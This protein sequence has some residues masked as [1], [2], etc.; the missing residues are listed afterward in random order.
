MRATRELF[1]RLKSSRS[2][3]L[4][5]AALAVLVIAA[6]GELTGPKSPSTPTGVVATLASVTSATITWTPSPLNDGVIS[7]SIYRNGTKVG[8]SVTTSYTDTGLAQQ[9]T[10][11]YSVAANCKSG[12]ISERSLETA[13]ST[14]T[15]VDITPP[16][17]LSTI[18]VNGATGVS[19]A[20][21]STVTFSEPMDPTTINTSTFNIRVTSSGQILAGTVT[22][23]ATTRV[24][25]F[26]PSS[27]LPNLTDLTVTVT[28]GA[29]DLAGNALN[30]AFT[31]TWKTRDEDGPIV[32]SSS[33]TQGS[34]GVSPN[35]SISVTFNEAVDLATVIQSNFVLKVTSTGAT[36]PGQLTYDASTRTATFRPTSALSQTG[37]TF[38]VN[39][40]KDTGGN[41]MPAPFV[42]TFTVDTTAPTVT[43]VVP[44]GSNV[45]TNTTVQVTFSEAMDSA[46][47][48][49]ANVFLK[50]TGTGVVVA[51]SLAYNKATNVLTLTPSGPLS[52]ATNYTLTVTTGVKDVAGNAL[53][54]QFISNFT[55]V[56]L[57]DTTA[58]T[59]TSRSPTPGATDVAIATTVIVTFS[60]AMNQATIVGTTNIRLAPDSAP[61][62]TVAATLSYNSATNAATLTPTAPLLNNVTYRVTVT[63]GVTDVAGNALA[64]QTT[65]TF[66][67]IADTTPP[68]IVSTNPAGGRTNFPR[69]SVITVT[70]SEDMNPATLNGTLT[71]FT[72]KTT[73]GSTPV[74]GTVSYNTST[75][76]A[77]FTPTALLLAS[78]GY[79]VTV[80]TGAK[81]LAGNGLV[82]DSSFSFQTASTP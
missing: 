58:P 51:A 6:C 25:E 29:K 24:A 52:N 21:T 33:P 48:L 31:A 50:N 20:G 27:P 23:N 63:T 69:D 47:F 30:P 7:Y 64:S 2:T 36:V 79:T 55:T 53:A 75:R 28:A 1:M 22:Y 44:T 78:T 72:V 81:D 26:I 5:A 80:T 14:I 35:A 65:W 37:Y 9:T 8:E 60:E 42:L 77:V 4:S 17:V 39:G 73:I 46:T 11:V 76:T 13:Q 82:V 15:T 34:P 41:L 10:Y 38:T 40:V 61:G 12:V 18:P 3:A 68:T 54:A 49:P 32:I 16:R 74:S 57:A 71:N 45:A 56:A 59:I 67:T 62:S 70:F 66:K 43:S 19:R